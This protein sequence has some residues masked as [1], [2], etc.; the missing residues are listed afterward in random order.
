[1]ACVCSMM[2]AASARK[3]EGRKGSLRTAGTWNHLEVSSF[4]HLEPGLTQP[5]LANI[6]LLDVTWVSL[7]SKRECSKGCEQKEGVPGEKGGSGMA[8]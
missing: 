4:M 3:L 5:G 1:M 7:S 6:R 2:S 8:I